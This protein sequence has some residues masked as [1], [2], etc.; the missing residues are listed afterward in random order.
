MKILAVDTSSKNCSVAIVEVDENKNFNVIVE[1][2][3]DDEKT[4]S[5]KL[6][7]LVDSALKENNLSLNDINLLA[8]CLGPGSFTGIRIGIATVKAFADAK[9]IPT[10]GVTSFESLAYNVGIKKLTCNEHLSN[11]SNLN[12]IICPIID[13]KNENVYSALFSCKNNTYLQIGDNI[14]ENVNIVLDGFYSACDIFLNRQGNLNNENIDNKNIDNN[15]TKTDA[16]NKITFVG[17]GS[18]L[19]KDLIL[20]K[21]SNFTVEFAEKNVQS[22]ISLA[23]CAYIKYLKGLYGDS[24][25]ISPLY[26]RKSQAERQQL[27]KNSLT[28]SQMTINDLDEIKSILESD[29]DEFWNYEALNDEL[30]SPFSKFIVARNLDNSIVGYAGI[31]V[32]LDEADL[33]NIVTRKNMRGLGV[34]SSM[35]EYI[36]SYCRQN[37]IKKINL[38]VNSS[39]SIAINLYK[40]Y[41][42][43]EVGLRKKYYNNTYDAIL[44]NLSI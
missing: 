42:F 40:K 18:I 11:N 41:N 27:E 22:S 24:N 34:A 30:K 19:Y 43:K 14:A 4:H 21:F 13:C 1:K 31:K 25:Y 38:E 16:S 2:N 12:T 36:I 35:L 44:M 39:N 5:Q 3:S 8:C 33:M 29:F 9:N 15:K 26:L 28:I 7:P 32:V 6:M 37:E 23:K 10:V 20:E 17:D